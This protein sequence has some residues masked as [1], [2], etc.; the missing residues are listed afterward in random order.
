MLATDRR[1][2]DAEIQHA[3]LNI[4]ERDLNNLVTFL[5]SLSTQ[6]ALLAGFAFASFT[7]LPADTATWIKI[8]LYLSTSISIGANLFVV[9]VGQLA[10]IMGPTLALKGPRGSMER[11]VNML[12]QYRQFIFWSFVVG[13]VAFSSTVVW[14]L[15][16]YVEETALATVCAIVLG[17]FF[18]IT[19]GFSYKV[20]ADFAFKRPE[21]KYVIGKE[22]N[23]VGLGEKRQDS[24]EP[25]TL[26]A[27]EF[28]GLEPTAAQ[29]RQAGKFHS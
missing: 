16:I 2:L 18:V 1:A 4:Q 9:C 15:V 23:V 22:L 17:L 8:L 25:G 28:L 3:R 14:L 21:L 26:P 27:S 11:A 20:L 24:I 6:S 5:D 19:F 10:T 29:V 12:R 7:E 13:L